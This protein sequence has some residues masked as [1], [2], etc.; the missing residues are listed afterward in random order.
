MLD[1]TSGSPNSRGRAD[2][3]FHAMAGDVRRAE[4]LAAAMADGGASGM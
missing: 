3:S 4:G 1:S 2:G